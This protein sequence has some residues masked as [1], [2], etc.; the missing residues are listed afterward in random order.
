MR[1][2]AVDDEPIGRITNGVQ[3]NTLVKHAIA[4]LQHHLPEWRDDPHRAS[5]Q[6]EDRL[7]AQLPKYLNRHALMFQFN[8][9]EPQPGSRSV[10]LAVTPIDVGFFDGQRLTYYDCFLYIECKRLPTPAPQTRE[11]EYVTGHTKHSGAVQRFKLGVHGRE[12]N[13][14]VIIGYVQQGACAE[15]YQ[16]INGWIDDLI[17]GN[18]Q[19]GCTWRSGEQITNYTEDPRGLAR[20]ESLHPRNDAQDI[21]IIHLWIDMFYSRHRV[22]Q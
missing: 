22:I 4:F 16:T 19:D 9:Q 1:Y 20:S 7:T 18:I 11:Q 15:W 10:D 12:H 5:E 14:T 8:Q 3:P 6:A 21:H 17:V 13:T 2:N